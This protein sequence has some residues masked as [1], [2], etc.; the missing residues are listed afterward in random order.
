[1]LGIKEP[2]NSI[3]SY[4]IP[5]DEQEKETHGSSTHLTPTEQAERLLGRTPAR[6]REMI[7]RGELAQEQVGGRWL[8]PIVDVNRILNPS[9][10]PRDH[11]KHAGPNDQ[12]SSPDKKHHEEKLHEST[13]PSQQSINTAP[14]KKKT[15]DLAA[16]IERLDKRM[17]Q[18]DGELRHLLSGFINDEKRERI[19]QLKTE[20]R[21][22]GKHMHKLQ[23][24]LSKIENRP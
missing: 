7:Q 14:A 22:R 2:E 11:E 5:M 17:S 9:S 8:I 18:I 21:K 6:V 4:N 1:V 3:A 10:E 15:R 13:R 19:E 16:E 24:E 20:K 23:R 12:R